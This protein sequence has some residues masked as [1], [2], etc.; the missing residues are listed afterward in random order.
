MP[1]MRVPPL[2]SFPIPRRRAGTP[3]ISPMAHDAAPRSRWNH[4]A[5]TER[6][7]PPKGG[8][9]SVCNSALPAAGGRGF[10]DKNAPGSA[11]SGAFTF[12]AHPRRRRR[13]IRPLLQQRAALFSTTDRQ[14]GRHPAPPV[15]P[16]PRTRPSARRRRPRIAV[17]ALLQDAA[18]GRTGDN[19]AATHLPPLMWGGDA[20][21][22]GARVDWAPLPY[23][24]GGGASGV[25]PPRRFVAGGTSP[26]PDGS[27]GV[28]PAPVRRRR[29][30][31]AGGETPRRRC[32]E[33]PPGPRNRGGA[34]LRGDHPPDAA[35]TARRTAAQVA[36]SG[37]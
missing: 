32:V 20:R 1:R 14:G 16:T 3:P 29:M 12:P 31:D 4:E 21:R 8:G 34:V 18:R 37:E 28:D 36:G 35:A 25:A 11:E 24:R 17:S 5:V 6:P 2:Q 22:G 26:D 7:P 33:V 10:G 13:R 23:G 9:R 30:G 15:R 19:H 27:G